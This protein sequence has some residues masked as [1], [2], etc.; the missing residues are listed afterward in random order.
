MVP[1]FEVRYSFQKESFPEGSKGCN[2]NAGW[3]IEQ[4]FNGCCKSILNGADKSGKLT[5]GWTDFAL[6]DGNMI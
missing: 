2:K 5:E 3:Q 1:L 6:K 4:Y